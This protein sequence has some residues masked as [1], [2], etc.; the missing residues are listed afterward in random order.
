MAVLD[1]S[2]YTP[3]DSDQ[4]F[5]PV[6]RVFPNVV[7]A[8]LDD[9]GNVVP[10]GEFGEICVGGVT[11]ARGYLNQPDLN[12][13]R[14]I[15]SDVIAADAHNREVGPTRARAIPSRSTP[16]PRR[17]H[18]THTGAVGGG[19]GGLPRRL[20]ATHVPHRRHGPLPRRRQPGGRGPL[21]RGAA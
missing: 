8:L 19:G 4:R 7:V 5:T 11:L 21:V 13:Q 18:V 17:T 6:G 3:E 1:L 20:L 16:H 12:A 15:A 14:F 2:A 10:Q 9:D